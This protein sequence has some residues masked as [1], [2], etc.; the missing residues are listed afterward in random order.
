[1][2]NVSTITTGTV[3]ENPAKNPR[4]KAKLISRLFFRYVRVNIKI[5]A[6]LP[7]KMHVFRQM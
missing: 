7:N 2:S 4:A 5:A 1:M 3:L 6:W